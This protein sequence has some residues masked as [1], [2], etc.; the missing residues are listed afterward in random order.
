MKLKEILEKQ[1]LTDEQITA[2]Q[3]SMTENKVYETT[4]E[5]AENRVATL[6][7]EKTTLTTQL[8]T[9]NNRITT[10]ENA[11]DGDK[12]LK[13][14]IVERDKTIQTLEA[15][16]KQRDL[17]DELKGQGC[18]NPKAVAALLD[19]SKLEYKDGKHAGLEEQIKALKESDSY[20]FNEESKPEP[21]GT[22]GS[23]DFRGSG[24]KGKCET[25]SIGTRLVKVAKE[26]ST[27]AGDNP[28]FK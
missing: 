5:N 25:E 23:G 11:P 21:G 13:D 19:N 1:G 8:E 3:Q 15:S 17:Y 26:S 20:L 2:I 7:N 24:N 9:A 28:Y 22:G 12:K 10:L 27:F 4:V 16:I 6:E 14:T 18:K